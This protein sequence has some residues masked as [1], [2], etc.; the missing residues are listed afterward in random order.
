MQLEGRN[1]S[2]RLCSY[3]SC[4]KERLCG[5]FMEWWMRGDAF[6]SVEGATQRL[7]EMLAAVI[8]SDACINVNSPSSASPLPSTDKL[9]HQTGILKK[10]GKRA[11]RVCFCF[12]EDV[13]S[14]E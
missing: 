6:V 10:A 1:V 13:S 7:Q 14:R 5:E 11:V 2:D 12:A 8:Q 3:L 4:V 9:L